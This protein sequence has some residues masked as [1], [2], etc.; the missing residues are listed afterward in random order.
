MRNRATNQDLWWS[1]SVTSRRKNS[2]QAC[3]RGILYFAPKAFCGRYLTIPRESDAAV[4]TL[5]YNRV[6]VYTYQNFQNI[7]CNSFPM[8]IH[9]FMIVCMHASIQ[10]QRESNSNH[11]TN[12][13][14]NALIECFLEHIIYNCLHLAKQAQ[15]N[16]WSRIKV[17][18]R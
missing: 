13:H 2:K 16:Q 1:H 6:P 4:A 11:N 5:I 12:A 10:S 9:A 3:M 15:S 17:I 18:Q 14:W 8:T 7:V